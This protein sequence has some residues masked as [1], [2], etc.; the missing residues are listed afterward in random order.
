MR[1]ELFCARNGRR[2]SQGVHWVQVHPPGRRKNLGGVKFTGESCKCT[3][4]GGECTPEAEQ[5]F[6]FEEIGEIWTVW[7]RLFR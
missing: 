2:P 4:P 6:I 1:N 7:E 5:E 3:I